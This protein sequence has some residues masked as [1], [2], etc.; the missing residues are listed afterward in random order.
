M[1]MQ[2]IIFGPK[3]RQ[4]PDFFVKF[5]LQ[6]HNLWTEFCSKTANN[7]RMFYFFQRSH[8][9]LQHHL[10]IEISSRVIFPD[11]NWGFVQN[12]YR[13]CAPLI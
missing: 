2:N 11:N 1:S 5:L 9:F 13:L 4:S 7:A 3:L 6:I 8:Y 12:Y 10:Q